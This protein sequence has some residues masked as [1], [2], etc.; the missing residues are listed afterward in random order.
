MLTETIK[1][2]EV[3]F[4]QLLKEC[5]KNYKSVEKTS[6]HAKIWTRVLSIKD[7]VCKAVESECF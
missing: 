6:A 5:E 3:L 1:H 4:Q 7:Q 2:F